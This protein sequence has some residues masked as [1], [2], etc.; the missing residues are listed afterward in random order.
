MKSEQQSADAILDAGLTIQ[1]IQ[2][3]LYS[4]TSVSSNF[5]SACC[6]GL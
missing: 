1:A 4:P 5:A 2:L 3:Y 6:S